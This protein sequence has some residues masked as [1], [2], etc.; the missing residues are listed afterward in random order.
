[1]CSVIQGRTCRPGED[2][3]REGLRNGRDAL[4][5]PVERPCANPATAPEALPSIWHGALAP[6]PACSS[7]IVSALSCHVALAFQDPR[8]TLTH[9]IYLKRLLIPGSIKMITLDPRLHSFQRLCWRAGRGCPAGHGLR[10]KGETAAEE[11]GCW[12]RLFRDEQ[13]KA[14]RPFPLARM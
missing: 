6:P 5:Y 13:T 2:G 1:M 7:N 9:S 14:G 4:P 10:R 12:G 3:Q 8:G 11:T